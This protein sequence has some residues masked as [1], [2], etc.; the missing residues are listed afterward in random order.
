MAKSEKESVYFP[1]YI[2]TRNDRKV[3]RVRRELGIEGYGIFFMLLE[4]LREQSD[5]KYPMAD[6]DLLA[7]EFGTSE[8]KVRV[9]ICNYQLFEVDENE[10]FYSPKQIEYLMPYFLK[11]KRAKH[12]ALVRWSKKD[13]NALQMHSDSKANAMQLKERKGKETKE[14]QSNSYTPDFEEAWV[15][16]RRKGGKKAAYQQ[17]KNLSQE[18]K[19]KAKNHIPSYVSTRELTYQKDFERYLKDGHY[20]SDVMGNTPMTPQAQQA[21]LYE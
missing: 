6:I 15:L 14:K 4:V 7:D 13:A 3:R 18:E 12:A 20:E 21:S 2:N 1:H 17:W 9:V 10:F 19:D 16:Y 11:S 5:L 8:Q